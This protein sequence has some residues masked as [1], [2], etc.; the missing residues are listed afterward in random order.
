M[1]KYLL[2]SGLAMAFAFSASAFAMAD[3]V[4]YGVVTSFSGSQTASYDLDALVMSDTLK[5]TTDKSFDNVTGLKCAT[6]IGDKYYAYVGVFDPATYDEKTVFATINFE[7]GNVVEINNTSFS[8]PKPGWNINGMAY[9]GVNNVTYAIEKDYDDASDASITNLY[10]VNTTNGLLTTL[11]SLPGEY[12]CIASDNNGGFYLLNYTIDAKWHAFPQLYKLNADYTVEQVVANEDVNASMS[13]NVSMIASK[14]GNS[15]Y[16]FSGYKVYAFDLV[17]KTFA[18]KGTLSDGVLGI[19]FSKSSADGEVADVPQEKAKQTRFMVA[20]YNYGGIPSVDDG[21]GVMSQ[22]YLYNDELDSDRKLYYYNTDGKMIAASNESRNVAKKKFLDTYTPVDITKY[23]LDN[24]GNVAEA[25]TYQWGQY[26]YED[27]CWKKTVNCSSYKY[28]ENGNVVEEKSSYQNHFY[29]YNEDGTLAMDSVASPRSNQCVSVKYCLTYEDGKLV[30][31]ADSNAYSKSVTYGMIMY[32]EDG[33]KAEELQYYTKPDPEFPDYPMSVNTQYEKWEYENGN[34]VA[35]TK[36]L[37]DEEGN[38][39]PSEKILYTAIDGDYNNI[40][41]TDSTYMDGKWYEAY[42]AKRQVYVDMADMAEQVAMEF[43]VEADEEEKNVVDLLFTLPS[44]SWNPQYET[45]FVIYR[46]CLPID[47]IS[48]FDAYNDDMGM[49]VYKDKNLRNGSYDYFI[50]PLFGAS[51]IDVGPLDL[52]DDVDVPTPEVEWV[53]YY[54]TNPQ[55]VVVNTELPAVTDLTLAGGEKKTTGSFVQKTTTYYGDLKWKNPE[56]AAD[57]GFKGNLVYF[58]GAGVPEKTLDN[59]AD[60]SV[61][62]TLYDEDA[63]AY[64]ATRYAL[65]YA[66]SDTIDIKLADIDKIVAGVEGVTVDGAVKATFSGNVITLSDNA[67]VAVYAANGQKVY[68]ADDATSVSLQSLP[69]A[70]Y[71]IVVEKNGKTNAYKYSVK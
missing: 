23:V 35:Y 26:D 20:Q 4:V 27:Y 49:C 25:N 54:S 45:K 9:D 47:T 14:D 70:T 1:K 63:Q 12:E 58:V 71:V 28:D 17:A 65:G 50:Q 56:N 57:Y 46:D 15:V 43:D 36:N 61:R 33:N 11:T 10:S 34:L 64:V 8:Y 30:E 21:G 38:E 48:A 69:A 44:L 16:F 2:N 19:T 66:I 55:T 59:V 32:D 31:Y 68:A 51:S 18:Q 42:P 60:D 6:S 7:T 5:V 24:A 37:F 39:V 53:G 52:D 41:M 67:N 13:S 40:L 3:N 22:D 29:T 62:V